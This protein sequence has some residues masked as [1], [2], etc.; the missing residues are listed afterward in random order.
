MRIMSTADGTSNGRSQT[1]AAPPPEALPELLAGFL[2]ALFEPADC[3]VIRPI[4]T[5][6]DPESSRKCSEVIYQGTRYPRADFFLRTPGLFGALLKI[7]QA[8]RANLFFGV[9]PRVGPKGYDLA[10]QIR[11]VRALWADLD[12]CTPEE[13]LMR[14]EAVCLPRP[15][16]VVN[17]GHGVHLYWLLAEP[18]LI[19]DADGPPPAVFKE[20]ID[21][22]DGRKK[23]VREYIKD[24]LN[25]EKMYLASKADRDGQVMELTRRARHAQHV[26]AGIAS[27][28]GGDHTQDLARLLRLPCTLNRKDERNGKP[29][30]PCELVECEPSRRYPFADFERF[31]EA[32]PEGVTEEEAATIRLPRGRK[33]SAAALNE[34]NDLLNVCAVAPVGKRSEADFHL[35][36][37]AI[38]KGY[39]KEAV[40]Q[41]AQHVGKFAESGRRYFDLTWTNAEEAVRQKLYQ[42]ARRRAGCTPAGDGHANGAGRA[43]GHG[44][45]KAE[46][47]A[48][49][50]GSCGDAPRPGQ[51][52]PSLPEILGNQRQLRD[53]TA[54]ALAALKARNDPPSVFQRGGVLTRLKV[55]EDTGAPWLEPLGPGALRGVLARAADWMTGK[56]ARGETV[57]EDD[58]PPMEVVDDLA[59][60]PAWDGIPVIDSVAE[61]PVFSRAGEL[62]AAPGFHPVVGLWLHPAPGLNV[63][64]V[65]QRPTRQ[66]VDEARA[67]L[68]VELFGDFPFKDDASRA[69][70]VAALLLP[71]I[72]RMVDGPTPLHLFDAPTEGTGK[73]LLANTISVVATGRPAEATTDPG[74]E[75][76]WRKKLTACLLEGPPIIFLDNLRAVLDSGALASALTARTW[77]DRL[78]GVSKT[79]ALPNYACWMASGNNTRLIRELIRRTVLTRLDA[80]MDCPWERKEF[81]HPKLLAWALENR[82]RLVWA[83]LTL[84]QAWIAKGRPA[85]T[86]TMGMFEGWAEVMGGVLEVAGIPGLLANAAEF[87][88]ARA[89]VVGEWRAFVLAWW[90]RHGECPV[91][92]ADLFLLTQEQKLLDSELGDKGE[93]SQRS[94]L[95]HALARMV[96]RVF[97][98]L[99]MEGAGSDHHECKLYRLRRV[100]RED[101]PPPPPRDS[102][103]EEEARCEG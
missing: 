92:V 19:D 85:G 80:E 44:H 82:G 94:R 99:R 10:W 67:W 65:S 11:T 51:A 23:K 75:A 59:N 95:G 14:C 93:R 53:V 27:K 74:S 24:P 32:A 30:V 45:A 76:E 12:H 21:Q 35:C 81:R 18:Y 36:A 41:Q 42:R 60:L 63:P 72:R 57:Y 39:D 2:A 56:N 28:L 20:F 97:G 64:L 37:W 13:A 61:C 48:A 54:D 77:K 79:V 8:N 84:C 96:D 101:A 69:H 87:R 47:G 102:A 98:D 73:T 90:E 52:E 70:A 17:S 66:E 78:L 33:L 46:G 4:E 40:W 15:S 1:K 100:G 25:G 88:K 43:G 16:V 71:S 6:T 91:G 29:P 55:R 68:L 3:F 7:S 103:E 9:C 50:A 22:G 58:A 49:P 31:A 26:L 38:E 89:D 34:L 86:G 83:A 5:W 62:V